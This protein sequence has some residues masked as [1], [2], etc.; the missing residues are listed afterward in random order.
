MSPKKPLQIEGHSNALADS[1]RNLLQGLAL[2]AVT[3]REESEEDS[4]SEYES[5]SSDSDSEA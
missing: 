1:S 5:E 4:S 3:E 2:H